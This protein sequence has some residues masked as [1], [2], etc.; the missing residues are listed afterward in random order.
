MDAAS[1]SATMSVRQQFMA[2]VLAVALVAVFGATVAKDLGV[3]T[4][5][6][7]NAIWLDPSASDRLLASRLNLTSM[8]KSQPT[9]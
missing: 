8:A 9:P 3:K 2:G 6:S 4:Q 1:D 7:P 5:A